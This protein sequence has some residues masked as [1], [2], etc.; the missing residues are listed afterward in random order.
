MRLRQDA[1][2]VVF[3]REVTMAEMSEGWGEAMHA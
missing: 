2:S 1:T 3:S